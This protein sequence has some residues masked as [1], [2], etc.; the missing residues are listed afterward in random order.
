[1]GVETKNDNNNNDKP[2]VKKKN[3]SSSRKRKNFSA[4]ERLRVLQAVDDCKYGEQK[5]VLLKLGVSLT[6]LHEFRKAR[7][8]I[9]MLVKKDGTIVRTSNGLERVK[10]VITEMIITNSNRPPN[11]QV[12]L[13]WK[14]IHDRAI[15][16]RS[17][18]LEKDAEEQFLTNKERGAL[19]AFKASKKWCQQIK[20]DTNIT[21]IARPKSKPITTITINGQKRPSSQLYYDPNECS[22]STEAAGGSM[23]VDNDVVHPIMH[24]FT[25]QSNG[26]ARCTP[27]PLPSANIVEKLD[28]PIIDGST[29]DVNHI[30]F[31]N[32]MENTVFFAHKDST[33]SLLK[34]LYS[35]YEQYS[36]LLAQL[37]EACPSHLYNEDGLA[38]G[39]YLP[40]G[41][42]IRGGI[43]ESSSKLPFLIRQ[44]A[45][46]IVRKICDIYAKIAGIQALIAEKYC[47]KDYVENVQTYNDGEDC[48][49]P[50]PASQRKDQE[51]SE[52]LHWSQHQV[53]LRIMNNLLDE[54][55]WRKYRI[56]WHAD[57]TD[58]KTKQFLTFLPM[59]GKDGKGG[60]VVDSDL[61]VFEH[62]NGGQCYRVRTSLPGTVVFVLMN[63]SKQLHGN[64]KDRFIVGL[65]ESAWSLR[66]IAYG[67]QSVLNFTRRR[68][69]GKITGKAFWGTQVTKHVP[70][71][72]GEYQEGKEVSAMFGKTLRTATLVMKSD[73]LHFLWE[74]SS[75]TKC[76][77]SNIF[78]RHCSKCNANMCKHCNPSFE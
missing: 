30:Q 34:R 57:Q 18:L 9:E 60:R 46:N 20:K 43:Q 29:G 36:G 58:V 38:G 15:M 17:H 35:C 67:R 63:S 6:S 16:T 53:A 55:A 3:K 74:D 64:A 42:A 45:Y 78:S 23:K 25:A 66:F 11:N 62:E 77:R 70:L 37:V 40:A 10:D 13:T 31:R 52:G 2:S 14:F 1:M 75:T 47:P 76:G 44:T 48:I 5:H 4:L 68:E 51:E 69:S 65:D 49:F 22:D 12:K 72:I 41:I 56:A 59:G 33:C 7:K 73:G 24:E 27:R 28:P 61:V 71:G 50:P 21:K 19:L 8:S 32:K 26:K 39:T 54:E